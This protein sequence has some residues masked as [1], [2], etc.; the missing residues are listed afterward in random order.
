LHDHCH[1]KE[2][3]IE[4]NH[5][6]KAYHA[7]FLIMAAAELWDSYSS[8]YS[9]GFDPDIED[10]SEVMS[11]MKRGEPRGRKHVHAADFPW[12]CQIA[13]KASHRLDNVYALTKWKLSAQTFSSPPIQLDPQHTPTIPKPKHVSYGV[14]IAYSIIL[15]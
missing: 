9:L 5:I 8:Y 6:N 1:G 7:I 14:A 11:R 12:A 15:A 4:T 3:V 10:E 2:I 13:A